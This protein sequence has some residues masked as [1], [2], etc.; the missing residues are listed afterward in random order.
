MTDQSPEIKSLSKINQTVG[1]Q[2]ADG[3]LGL[4]PGLSRLEEVIEKFGPVDQNGRFV[5]GTWYEFAAGKI[6]VTVLDPGNQGVISKIRIISGCAVEG[7]IPDN[8]AEAHEIF[9]RLERAGIEELCTVIYE[10]PG[11]RLGCELSGDQ[12]KVKWIEYYPLS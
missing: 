5:N 3:W 2:P 4:M 10:R 12:P 9:G 8:L 6:Q 1:W 7:A 11:M